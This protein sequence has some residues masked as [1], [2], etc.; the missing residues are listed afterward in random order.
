MKKTLKRILIVFAITAFGIIAAA[1]VGNRSVPNVTENSSFRKAADMAIDKVRQTSVRE[2]VKE[3]TL[4]AAS[5]RYAEADK[6]ALFESPQVTFFTED[7]KSIS[8]VA[9]QGLVSTDSDDMDAK[10]QVILK[11]D[12]YSLSTERIRYENRP[13]IF[14]SD[15]PVS[16]A[17]DEIRL[18][19]DTMSFDIKTNR[20]HLEGNVK[21]IFDEKFSL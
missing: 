14:S 4:D 20:L 15:V 7:G 6:Q 17:G 19:A 3:W 18:T 10:G 8:L 5:V 13:R 21:G 11:M 9:K 1:F 12:N 16:L 2:G